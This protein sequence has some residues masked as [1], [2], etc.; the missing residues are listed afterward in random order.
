[1]DDEDDVMDFMKL[2]KFDVAELQSGAI[3]DTQV[4]TL[5]FKVNILQ[6]SKSSLFLS[7]KEA[8]FPRPRCL[9]LHH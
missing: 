5:L 6:Y 9:G 1:M 2:L 7:L 4:L 8:F 3:D